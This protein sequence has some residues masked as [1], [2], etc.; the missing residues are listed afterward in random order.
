MTI[1]VILDALMET[2]VPYRVVTL[3]AEHLNTIEFLVTIV[4][5]SRPLGLVTRAVE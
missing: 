1:R 3:A 5:V 4:A 2:A